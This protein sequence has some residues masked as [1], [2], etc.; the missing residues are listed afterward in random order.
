[1]TDKRKQEEEKQP[2]VKHTNATIKKLLKKNH[3]YYVL[4]S[5]CIGLRIYIS[6][7]GDI[8]FYLQRYIP[9]YR[10]SKRTKIGDFHEMSITE[11]RKL[12]RL[13]KA[14]NVQGKDPI[15]AKAARQKE[16][17]FG[18]VVEEFQ[19]KKLNSKTNKA[20]SKK[21]IEDEKGQIGAYILNTSNDSKIRKVWKK[22]S[23]EMNIKSR[24]LSEITAEDIFD[25]HGA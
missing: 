20:R 25:Y 12:G 19:I 6:I 24:R 16:N 7:T 23:E 1:M 22:Y 9:E 10:Y 11:A 3:P 18:I 14:D 5:E 8:S 21:S 15:L 13:I 17:T 2:R 4:D